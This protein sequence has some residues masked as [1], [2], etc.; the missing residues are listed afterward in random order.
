VGTGVVGSVVGPVAVT[1][2]GAVDTL[3]VLGA[4]DWLVIP[5]LASVGLGSGS[6]AVM[7]GAGVDVPGS[8]DGWPLPVAPSVGLFSERHLTRSQPGD[9]K[10]YG[11]RHLET[12]FATI[13][14]AAQ[15]VRR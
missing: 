3:L 12:M 15:S 1:V 8:A 6:V 10:T 13:G 11:A 4:G 7:L 5:G 14:A 2:P 9:E